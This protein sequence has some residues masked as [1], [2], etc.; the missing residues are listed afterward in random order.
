[1]PC[2]L[3][4]IFSM[5]IMLQQLESGLLSPWSWSEREMV[6]KAVHFQHLFVILGNYLCSLI[7]EVLWLL[8][9]IISSCSENATFRVYI[10]L[11]LLPAFEADLDPQVGGGS[12]LF[13]VLHWVQQSLSG[14]DNSLIKKLHD[15]GECKIIVTWFESWWAL[16]YF[17]WLL[18]KYCVI[19]IMFIVE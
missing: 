16:D 7:Y 2:T 17:I 13:S 19:T 6:E 5:A 4:L 15:N 10:V 14:H 8:K 3:S 18:P 1:M 9:Y 12:P 11:P